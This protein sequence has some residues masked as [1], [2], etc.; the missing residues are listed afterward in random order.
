M[1]MMTLFI[2]VFVAGYCSICNADLSVDPMFTDGMVLQRDKSI[3]VHGTGETGDMVTL[4]LQDQVKTT[5]V[6]NDGRWTITLDPLQASLQPRILT[7]T[8]GASTIVRRDVLV[9]DVWICSGQSNMAFKLTNCIGGKQ[10]AEAANDSFLRVNTDRDSWSPC[11]TDT[12]AATSGVAYFFARALRQK[13][14]NVPVGIIV[15]A[16][17]GTPIEWWTPVEALN[18]VDFCRETMASLGA[19]TEAGGRIRAFVAAETKWKR[20]R[21]RSKLDG[22][23]VGKKPRF[24]GTS[25][26][27]VLAGIYREG[28]PGKLWS[29][30]IKPL[31]GYAI[32]GVIWYQ[33]ERNTKAGAANAAQYEKILPTMIRSWRTA[34]GQDEFRFLVVQLPP[35]VKGGTN[36]TVVQNGQATG[37]SQ[38]SNAACVDTSDLPDAGLHPPEKQPIGERLASLASE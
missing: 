21:R 30:R 36:W 16:M 11:V 32:A 25:E 31:V 26:E 28:H 8:S 22:G 23:T 19:G 10:A 33:G 6:Q 18:E 14:P 9:G 5:S 27:L 29:Q 34:W 15:R 37:V 4:K 35:F 24:E 17:S 7:I 38:I 1:N 20:S 2:S 12:A 3:M 13:N